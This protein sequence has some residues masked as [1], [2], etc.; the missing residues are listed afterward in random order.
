MVLVGRPIIY[1]LAVGVSLR[2]NFDHENKYA[3]FQGAEGVKHVIEILRTEFDYAMRLS[4]ISSINQLRTVP[5]M[6]VHENY[7][8]SKL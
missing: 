1:G 5:R 7:Y 3:G 6:I 8:Y 2:L 4:G